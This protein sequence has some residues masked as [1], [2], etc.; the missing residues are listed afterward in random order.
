MPVVTA[1]G[2]KRD[3]VAVELDGAAWRTLPAAAVVEV[4]LGPGVD[5]DRTRARA[6]ARVLRRLRAERTAVRAVARRDH[7]RASLDR[8]LHQA[9]VGDV[10]R[11]EVLERAERAGLVDDTRFAERRAALL[12]DRGAGDLLVLDDLER[13]GVEE[14]LARATVAALA[15][16][17]E[18][19]ARIV[20]CRG[21]S[22][23]IVRYLAGRG[24]SEETLEPLIAEIEGGALP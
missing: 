5:L 7:T 20:E 9:G 19:A 15:P 2:A 18:R 8:R 21:R 17:A 10:V 24:F 13:H 11:G 22:P 23:R 3:G 12:A 6:L 16:E 1:L 4:G 14:S